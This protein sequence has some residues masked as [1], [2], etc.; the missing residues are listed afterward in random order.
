MSATDIEAPERLTAPAVFG[1]PD[2][3]RA[4]VAPCGPGTIGMCHACNPGRESANEDVVGVVPLGDEGVALVVADGCGGHVGGADAAREAVDA[5]VE[6]LDGVRGEEDIAAAM[7]VGIAQANHR[8]LALGRGAACTIAMVAIDG[9]A[10][11]PAHV[12]DSEIVI[13]GQRGRE[14]FR[15]IPHSPTGYALESGLISEAQALSHA[16]RHVVSNVVGWDEMR[17]D[18][19]PTIQL[20]ARDTVLVASDGLFDNLLFDEIKTIIRKGPIEEVVEALR[21]AATGRMI[22]PDDGMPSKRDDLSFVVYRP[23]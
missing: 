18:M 4:L 3:V 6:A 19:G 15:C 14:H 22:E 12:G 5:V 10:A 23:A 8:V 1:Q 7:L 9:R 17:I 21:E 11:R 20:A 2:G 13:V 16:Q